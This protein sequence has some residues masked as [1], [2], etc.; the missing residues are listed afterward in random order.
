[1]LLF[2]PLKI[3]RN[4]ARNVLMHTARI[5]IWSPGDTGIPG[6]KLEDPVFKG[7]E[8]RLRLVIQG[9]ECCHCVVS[10]RGGRIAV[11]EKNLECPGDG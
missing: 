8:D 4:R 1:M 11:S 3:V 6:R 10:A 2:F 5:A 9:V 7:F